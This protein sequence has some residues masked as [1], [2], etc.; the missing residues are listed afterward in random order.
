MGRIGDTRSHRSAR[1]HLESRKGR[2]S[3]VSPACAAG[4]PVATTLPRSGG[5]LCGV[6]IQRLVYRSPWL[7]MAPRCSLMR[8]TMRMNSATMRE[9]MVPTMTLAIE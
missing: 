1:L 6:A 7:R 5:A 3:G 9:N 8:N 2:L 4:G